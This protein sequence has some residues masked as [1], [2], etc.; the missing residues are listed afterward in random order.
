MFFVCGVCMLI[1]IHKVHKILTL[2]LDFRFLIELLTRLLCVIAVAARV[3]D[4]KVK[5]SVGD[6]EV[7]Y[8]KE[9]F[10]NF[11]RDL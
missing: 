10:P 5:F 7:V 4:T 11:L 2:I 8:S 3:T 9:V 1:H 6:V